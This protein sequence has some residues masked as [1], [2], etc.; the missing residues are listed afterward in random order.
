M[1]A[2][3]R[4]AKRNPRRKAGVAS[5]KRRPRIL[6]FSITVEAQK[7]LVVYK[8]NR[9]ADV[10]TFE[11]KSPHRPARR[12]PV[13]ETGYRCESA[14]LDEIKAARGPRAYARNIVLE[15]LDHGTRR[16]PRQLPLF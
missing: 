3:S 2:S 1:S 15:F 10:G 11:F 9:F 12:I 4:K 6:R 5:K 8:P 7:M 14:W 13:S 16:D